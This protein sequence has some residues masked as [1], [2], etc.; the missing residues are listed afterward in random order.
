[1]RKLLCLAMALLLLL[2]LLACSNED[3]QGDTAPDTQPTKAPAE[4][5][6]PAEQEKFTDFFSRDWYGWWCITGGAGLYEDRE[7]EDNWWDACAR[8]DT[9][10]GS[11]TL[12][13][14]ES[15][16][17]EPLSSM[18]AQ[19]LTDGSAAGCL[20]AG[21]GTFIN[22]SAPKGYWLISPKGSLYKD[23]IRIHG[24]YDDPENPGSYF[25]YT[26]VLKPWGESWEDVEIAE[27][28]Y[29][30]ESWYLPLIDQG[31]PMPDTMG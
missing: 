11:L 14:Q 31:K 5:L 17:S 30:Y 22:M 7:R 4:P 10:K 12:W 26:L 28:P 2:T 16:L 29:G 24:R 9:Q 13:D 20:M 27:R 6:K 23:M 18:Q 25:E 1:M 15:S 21:E 3:K 8:I 19:L